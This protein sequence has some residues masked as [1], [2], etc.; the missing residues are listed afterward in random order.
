VL[1]EEASELGSEEAPRECDRF[2]ERD[3]DCE[4]EKLGSVGCTE[5]GSYVGGSSMCEKRM[6]SNHARE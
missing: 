1:A 5:N 2:I 4:R 6:K 3:K